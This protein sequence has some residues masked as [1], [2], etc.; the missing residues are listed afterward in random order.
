MKKSNLFILIIITLLLV[1][2]FI[3]RYNESPVNSF[4]EC[5]NK[6]GSSIQTTYPAICVSP[7]SQRFTDGAVLDADNVTGIQT[8]KCCPCPQRINSSQIG[9]NGWRKYEEGK[10]Y[11]NLLP[12]DCKNVFCS[13][14]QNLVN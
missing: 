5:V 2:F 10:D 4:E 1:L 11:T 6:K 3:F 9:T 8:N 7:D 13:P 12:N 14:C